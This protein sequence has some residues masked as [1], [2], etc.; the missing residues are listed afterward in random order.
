[1]TLRTKTLAM[2]GVLVGSFFA[3]LFLVVS[4]ILVNGF[5]TV[6]N[7][8]TVQSTSRA[9]EAINDEI[10][11]LAKITG[12]WAPWDDTYTFVQD[13]NQDFIESN[14]PDSTFTNLD[15]HLMLFANAANEVVYGKALLPEDAAD[16]ALLDELEQHVAQ[17]SF[18]LTHE[19]THSKYSGFINL[20]DGI[21]LL[22]SQ[23]I[24]TSNNE[25]PIAGTLMI[26]R[27]LDDDL[28][29]QLATRTRSSIKVTSLQAADSP[30]DFQQALSVLG[31]GGPDSAFVQ[32][33]SEDRIAGYA[34][35][36]DVYGESGL[37]VRI[38]TPRPVYQQ[39]QASL[40]YL[41]LSLVAVG[42]VSIIATLL[43]LERLVL[44]RLVRLIAGV[45]D[46]GI[47]GEMSKRLAAMGHD[48]LAKLALA[49]NTMLDDLQG[50]LTREKTLKKE[51]EQ[52]RIVIDQKKRQEQVAEITETE[53]FQ[54]LQQ[55]AQAMREKAKESEQ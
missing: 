47:S 3:V 52:L 34:V 55:T 44:A 32:P 43:T 18:L 10:D 12:D 46:I 23:P 33:L 38:D 21:L 30:A 22:A 8:A 37:A 6:E 5:A 28:I 41:A 26:G 7:Q 45:Q 11:N 15:I 20:P 2:I 48:E 42:L 27:L 51:V 49:I 4:A 31:G 36:P 16:S 1:M 24:L 17:N 14:L 29:G 35:L 13:G 54:H 50:A 40:R 53:Y 19:D 9:V 25:G 39:G